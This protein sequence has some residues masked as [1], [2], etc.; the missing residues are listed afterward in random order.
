MTQPTILPDPQQ[1]RLC[2]LSAAADDT[3]LAVVEPTAASCACPVCGRLARRVHSRYTRQLADLPW[4]GIAFRLQVRSRKFFCDHPTCP[5][6]IFTQRFPEFVAPYARRTRRLAHLL[7]LVAALVGGTPGVRLLVAAG[8]PGVGRDSLLRLVRRAVPVAERAPTTVVGIDDFSWRRGRTFGTIL[9][10]LA[11]HQVVDLLPTATAAAA[12]TWLAAH[13]QLHI[14]SRDRAGVYAEGARLGAPQAQQVADRW[15]LCKNLGDA[16]ET[17]LGRHRAAL[18]ALT[19]P[20]TS[21]PTSPQTPAQTSPLPRHGRQTGPPKSSAG[22]ARRREQ[23]ETVKRLAAQGWSHRRIAHHLHLNRRTVIRYHAADELPKRGRPGVA[24]LSSVMPF[25]RLLRQG[26]DAGCHRG[27]A[28]LAVLRAA[29][30]TGSLASVYRT[31]RRLGLALDHPAAT[32]A[33]PPPLSPRQARWL[34]LRASADLS[35]EERTLRE[36]LCVR[37]PEVAAALPLAQRFLR[38]IRTRAGDELEPWLEAVRT[39]GVS[40]LQRFAQQLRTDAAAVAGALS[41]PWSQG[42][43]EG[44]VNRLKLLKRQMYGRAK[45]DLLRARLRYRLDG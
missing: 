33:T 23:F 13:P 7:E 41:S 21:P 5:R 20:P 26:Y 16:L 34:L 35:E 10:D 4:H 3:I 19:R 11:R 9:V 22:S 8:I 37:C 2:A 17:L 27:T 29:G 42:Q 39:S 40:E 25:E 24:V 15:H 43:T 36:Q 44:Q 14:V 18:R 38:L 30:Y 6:Q 12:Q 1:W 28:L 32:G 31:L 45:P